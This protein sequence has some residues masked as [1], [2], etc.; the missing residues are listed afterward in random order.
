M[1]PFIKC[2]ETTDDALRWIL[3]RPGFNV[4]LSLCVRVLSVVDGDCPWSLSRKQAHY[5]MAPTGHLEVA[6]NLQMNLPVTFQGRK[7]GK[8]QS[9]KWL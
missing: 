8:W 5:R 7:Q 3:T 6:V 4:A 2:I 9:S 1:V